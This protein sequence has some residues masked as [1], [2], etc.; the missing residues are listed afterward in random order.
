MRVINKEGAQHTQHTQTSTFDNI[1]IL[2]QCHTNFLHK[3]WRMC[4]D[5]YSAPRAPNK[6]MRIRINNNICRRPQAI[7]QSIASEITTAT[8]TW[9]ENENFDDIQI[10]KW[11]KIESRAHSHRTRKMVSICFC[12][13]YQNPKR[14]DR[15]VIIINHANGRIFH[16]ENVRHWP[17]E[18]TCKFYTRFNRW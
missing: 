17:Y 12:L 9:N 11:D 5:V 7:A 18:W 13:I 8:N 4:D 2:I 16:S 15:S 10:I 14:F 3:Q 6:Y 1:D